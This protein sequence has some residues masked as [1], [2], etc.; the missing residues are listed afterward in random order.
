MDTLST[1]V[2]TLKS[3]LAASQKK[4]EILRSDGI[5]AYN[6]IRDSHHL[7]AYQWH[8]GKVIGTLVGALGLH[9]LD[10][11]PH[12]AVQQSYSVRGKLVSTYT[13]KQSVDVYGTNDHLLRLIF[14]FAYSPEIIGTNIEYPS[15]D[16]LGFVGRCYDQN[17]PSPTFHESGLMETVR[18]N[19]SS[20][21]EPHYD[22]QN[23]TL[24]LALH[25][26]YSRAQIILTC[27]QR[28]IDRCRVDVEGEDGHGVDDPTPFPSDVVDYAQVGAIVK[29]TETSRPP[30][31][32]RGQT[33]GGPDES[34]ASLYPWWI[35]DD[36]S[37]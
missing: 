33:Y 32:S 36:P 2:S 21:F 6:A 30:H 26:W 27:L 25:T 1:Q 12:G 15:L 35:F 19:R 23:D 4:V 31:A 16:L 5:A 37:E 22:K 18:Y 20:A 3:K 17:P 13:F 9:P 34:Q 7:G 11:L 10:V 14:D 29:A 28:Y 8:K 24:S